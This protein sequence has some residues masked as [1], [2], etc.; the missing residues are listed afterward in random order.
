MKYFI[1]CCLM[2]FVLAQTDYT[3]SQEAA[4]T[5]EKQTGLLISGESIP[6]LP[7]EF[8]SLQ[9]F[10]YK[11]DNFEVL[12]LNTHRQQALDILDRA[13]SLKTWGYKRWGLKDIPYQKKCMIMCI[14]TQDQFKK[15][16]RQ[17]DIEPKEADSVNLDGSPRKVYSI[18]IAGEQGF[19]T[20]SLPEKIGKV[21]LMNLEDSKK[22]R[23]KFSEWAIAG[24]SFLNNDVATIKKRLATLNTDKPISSKEIFESKGGEQYELKAAAM[25]LLL[26]K[27]HGGGKKF[28]EFLNLA[29]V[30]N[31]SVQQALG[32]YGFQ[33]YDHFD[34]SY[35]SYIRNL[36][37]DLKNNKTPN[38]GVTWFVP[39]KRK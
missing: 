7:E 38:M 34:L 18:W 22:N 31:G 12:S 32:V 19:L 10:L 27:Q 9:W 29:A 25:C 1:L 36:V 5:K 21:N 13:E 8:Q 37:Y 33:D 20:N 30:P 14:P 35:N 15:W 39:K 4:P 11:T 16:L 24:M 23:V 26:R 6:S 3:I 2:V 28:V 17:D